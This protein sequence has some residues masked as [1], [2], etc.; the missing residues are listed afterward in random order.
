[1]FQS[2]KKIVYSSTRSCRLL[3]HAMGEKR[4]INGTGNDAYTMAFKML[5]TQV[6]QR[7]RANRWNALAVTSASAGEGKTLVAINTAM[8]MAAEIEQTVLLVDADMRAPAVRD[9]LSLPP[10][11]GLSE[12]LIDGVALEKILINPGVNGFVVLPGGRALQNSAEMLSSRRMSELV[13]ELKMR[14]PE[15]LVVFDLPPLLSTADALAF[16]PFVDAALLVVEEGVTVGDDIER[17]VQMLGGTHLLGTVLNKSR[18]T[19]HIDT[20][21]A[22]RDIVR[23]KVVTVNGD[24]INEIPGRKIGRVS[25]LMRR[26]K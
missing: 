22:H 9:Y 3:P 20:S 8:S 11:P 14:Y 12:Y 15:R 23:P 1:M 2:E 26:F 21:N 7:M 17:A 18:S 5:R 4:I 25:R 6:L 10:G 19:A 16:S 13:Q 24:V